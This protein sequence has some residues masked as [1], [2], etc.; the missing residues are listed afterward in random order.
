MVYF[1]VNARDKAENETLNKL[2]TQTQ[3]IITRMLGLGFSKEEIKLTSYRLM[4]IMYT[5]KNL[6]R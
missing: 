1:S 6:K 3:S 5:V 2:N 4:R